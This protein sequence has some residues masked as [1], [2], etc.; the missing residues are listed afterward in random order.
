MGP[1]AS[2]RGGAGLHGSGQRL[3]IREIL[4][5]GVQQKVIELPFAGVVFKEAED[6]LSDDRRDEGGE[7]T[8]QQREENVRGI[9]RHE[10]V[11][12]EHHQEN[13]DRAGNKPALSAHQ[14]ETGDAGSSGGDM[15]GGEG[16]ALFTGRAD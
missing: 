5:T 6:K 12:G 7:N 4:K 14:A 9:V 3:Y 11:P 10:I 1:A 8:D 15:T 13:P 2:G 16:E